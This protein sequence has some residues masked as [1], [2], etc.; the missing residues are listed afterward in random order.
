VRSEYGRPSWSVSSRRGA[1]VAWR[2]YDARSTGQDGLGELDGLDFVATA[3]LDDDV[4]LPA[5]AATTNAMHTTPITRTSQKPRSRIR[6][7]SSGWD[8]P[9]DG[10]AICQTAL[11]TAWATPL[12]AYA[13][14]A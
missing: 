1:R 13:A 14:T 10:D 11:T 12:P 2:R 3:P 6:E 8:A 5:I 7:D 4:R 9:V